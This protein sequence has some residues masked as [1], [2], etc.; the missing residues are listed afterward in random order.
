MFLEE[1]DDR[2]DRV[3]LWLGTVTDSEDQYEQ[4]FEQDSLPEGVFCPFCKDIGL[5]EEYD[6][7]YIGIIP[8]FPKVVSLNKLLVEAA[9]DESELPAVKAK[10]KELGFTKGN[11]VLWYSDPDLKISPDKKYNG[12]TYIGE[13]R[14]A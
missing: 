10:C 13:F 1:D 2:F 12:L 9:I 5:D 6:E 8:L 14:G 7:D 3:H 11:A 4:Y